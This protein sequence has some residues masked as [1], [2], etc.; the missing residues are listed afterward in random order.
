[1][2]IIK[3]KLDDQIKLNIYGISTPLLIELI[4][5]LI[6]IATTSFLL[7]RELTRNDANSITAQTIGVLFVISLAFFL[8]H[9]LYKR[10]YIKFYA[11]INKSTIKFEDSININISDVKYLAITHTPIKI[12]LLTIFN[13]SYSL[14]VIFENQTTEIQLLADIK[15]FYLKNFITELSNLTN[16]PAVIFDDTNV[17]YEKIK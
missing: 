3:D 12:N 9:L 14:K 15:L 6:L 1:M 4:V 5:C 11:I 7:I 2:K 17:Y 10:I 8:I 13:D 16:I